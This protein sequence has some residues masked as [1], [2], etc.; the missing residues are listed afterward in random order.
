MTK[1][2]KKLLVRTLLFLKNGSGTRLRTAY[3]PTLQDANPYNVGLLSSSTS[4]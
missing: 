2:I 1:K 4:I 3:S